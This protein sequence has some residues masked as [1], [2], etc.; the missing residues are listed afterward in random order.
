MEAITELA[1]L[2]FSSV[3]ISV[4]VILIGIKSVLSLFEWFIEKFGFETKWMKRKREDHELLIKTS[5]NLLELQK[6]H[7]ADILESDR[8]DEEMKNDIKNL[9]ELFVE[10][11]INDYRWEIIN[12]ADKISSGKTVSKECYRH[13]L[14]TYERYEKIIDER[15]LT[16]GEVEIS[17]QIIND[18]YKQ[19]LKE[20]SCL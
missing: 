16:N 18:S 17:I 11:Q 19:K 20:G 6:R 2:N 7:N 12:L 15:G 1:T 9:T 5:Q 13:A 4:F 14:S 10:K 8:H 3:F